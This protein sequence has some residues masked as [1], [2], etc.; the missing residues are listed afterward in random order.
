MLSAKF[1]DAL[2]HLAGGHLQG[3]WNIGQMRIQNPASEAPIEDAKI[4]TGMNKSKSL[5]S[6]KTWFGV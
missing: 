6:K 2:P 4:T 1:A 5:L 3:E